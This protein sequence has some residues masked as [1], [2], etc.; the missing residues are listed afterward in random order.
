MCCMWS[1]NNPPDIIEGT[2]PIYDIEDAF[3]I[4]ISDEEAMRLYDMDLDEAAQQIVRIRN[5][6]C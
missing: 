3:D 1:T 5:K 6:K 2:N 4:E